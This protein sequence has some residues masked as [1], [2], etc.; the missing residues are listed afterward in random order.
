ML[1]CADGVLMP[2]RVRRLTTRQ[3]GVPSNT[4]N[5]NLVGADKNTTTTAFRFVKINKSFTM[6]ISRYVVTV[7]YLHI[8]PML[9]NN[10][11][12]RSFYQPRYI[13]RNGFVNTISVET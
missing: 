4:K 3:N 12:I 2:A 11:T 13:Q 10:V 1:T 8:L 6:Q 9:V 7:K 5:N